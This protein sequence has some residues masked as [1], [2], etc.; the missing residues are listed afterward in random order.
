MARGRQAHN[1]GGR[2]RQEAIKMYVMKL[3]G[4]YGLVQVSV[5]FECCS[6]GCFL[7]LG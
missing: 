6:E 3:V 1:K 2:H 4:R 7:L 5:L